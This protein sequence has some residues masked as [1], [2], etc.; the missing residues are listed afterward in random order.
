[1][2][3]VYTIFLCTGSKTDNEGI[4][5]AILL[6]LDATEYSEGLDEVLA[7]KNAGI[8]RCKN[9]VVS[10][11]SPNEA[12]ELRGQVSRYLESYPDH[13]GLLMLRALSE[14]LSRDKDTEVV[15]E[16]FTASVSFALST[17]GLKDSS[18]F[19]FAAWAASFIGMHS[20]DSARDLVL[21]LVQ[22]Y[23]SRDLA[24]NL[25]EHLPSTLSGIPAWLLLAK[26]QRDCESLIIKEKD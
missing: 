21:Y 16:N 10:V 14:A 17:Y 3:F 15:R 18:V 12:A 23:P 8:G 22:T 13:P 24:R 9:L 6:L 7:S 5:K 20:R 2:R 25:I 26:L 19:E 11:R 1:M 4:H